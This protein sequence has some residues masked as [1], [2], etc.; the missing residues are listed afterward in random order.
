MKISDVAAFA[1]AASDN[2]ELPYWLELTTPGGVRRGPV[3]QYLS[4]A[5]VID[6]NALGT[7][8]QIDEADILHCDVDVS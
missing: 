7:R 8:V 4:T 5:I 1:R 2:D 3:V 6:E